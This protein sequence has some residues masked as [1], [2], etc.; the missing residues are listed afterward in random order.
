[1][2]FTWWLNRQDSTGR[3]LFSGGF[4][5]LDNLSAFDRSNLPVSGHLDQ[6]DATAW[7][8]AYCMAMLRIA[9]ALAERDPAYRDLQTTF[10]EHAV[11]IASA[12][13][14]SGLWD[15]ADGFYYDALRLPDGTSIPLKIHSMVGILPV[16]PATSVPRQATE[17]GAALG[18][19]FARF[20]A[21]LGVTQ[22]SLRIRGSLLEAPGGD[23]MI[24]SLLPPV[25]LERVLREVL[26]EDAF[27][28]PHGIR[29]LSRRHL[30]QPFSIQIDGVT[31]SIDY[32]PGESLTSLFGGNSNWRGPVWFPVNFLLI[33]SLLRWDEALGETFMVEFPTGS[34]NRLRLG[35]VAA[36][37]ARR[38]VSI[39]IPDATGARPVAGSYEK[40]RSD[41]EWRDLLLFHEYFHGE[42]GAG[43]GASHQTG[44]TGLVAHLLCRGGTLDQARARASGADLATDPELVEAASRVTGEGGTRGS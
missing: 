25:H 34:G 22:E 15:E 39:W 7:M 23:S 28:S 40:F 32:E 36:D 29:A 30:E 21:G 20:L 12:M 18:K 41:P 1:M 14:S 2:N 17:L 38:L 5:G 26:S 19:R 31:A 27:L 10:L 11:R 4:L 3:N 16:L 33:E 24:L 37:L 35:A 8:Y 43:I 6:S 44:W 13:G 42:T 9:T